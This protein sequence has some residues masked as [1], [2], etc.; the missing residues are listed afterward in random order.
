MS[1]LSVLIGRWFGRRATSVAIE[2]AERAM[3][4]FAE[5][6]ATDGYESLY[7]FVLSLESHRDLTGQQ[8]LIAALAH[9]AS[10]VRVFG[11]FVVRQAI[12]AICGEI[13]PSSAWSVR[14]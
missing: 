8:K 10:D 5:Y 11:E 14:P 3:Q 4:R 9:A 1:A 12:E 13:K 7:E 6:A 2:I